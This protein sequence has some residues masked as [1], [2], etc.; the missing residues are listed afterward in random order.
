MIS[1]VLFY[2]EATFNDSFS[3]SS[4]DICLPRASKDIQPSPEKSCPRYS[5]R[6]LTQFHLFK[7]ESYGYQRKK[8]IQ[9]QEMMLVTYLVN[10][11]KAVQDEFLALINNQKWSLVPKLLK[12][13]N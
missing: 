3:T 12:T 5:V 4:T 8:G 1:T 2:P 7:Y 9:I 13:N 10:G 6:A 11:K